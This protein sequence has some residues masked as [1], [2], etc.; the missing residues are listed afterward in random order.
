MQ[1]TMEV[2]MAQTAGFC[3][4]VDR[5]ITKAYDQTKNENVYTFGPIIHN[6]QV[7]DDLAAHGIKVINT[8]E[9]LQ[10]VPKGT[11]IMRSHGVEKVIYD[12]IKESGFEIID[13][14][15]PYVKRI[16]KLV[17]EHS[18]KGEKI[19]IIGD[20]KH[21][22]VVGIMGWSSTQPIVIKEIEEALALEFDQNKKVCIVS[23][24][25]FNYNKFKDLVEILRKKEYDIYVFNTICDATEKRQFEAAEIAKNVDAMIVIGSEQ[26]SNTQKLYEICKEECANTYYIQTLVDLDE[27]TLRSFGKVGITAGASTPN[28]I[29]EEV[30]RLCQR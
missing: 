17:E 21:P 3:F 7:V 22:E 4:G 19:V 1:I 10:K 30:Q 8:I 15:C 24:T 28:K 25:T 23:Q 27:E 6:N 12:R 26:S 11:V 2:I 5:A 18:N 9:E 20:Y 13:A 29:I 14:T 16:H